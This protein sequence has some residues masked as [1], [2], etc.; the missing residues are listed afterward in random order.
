MVISLPLPLMQ[1]EPGLLLSLSFFSLLILI[2]VLPFSEEI[3]T[4]P[5]WL[6]KAQHIS[7]LPWSSH[8]L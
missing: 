6:L 8:G 2:F 7:L 5:M 1:T 3:E 4:H